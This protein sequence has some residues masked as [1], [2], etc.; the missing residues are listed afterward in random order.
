M[1]VS[2]SKVHWE[3]IYENKDPTEVSWYQAAPELSLKLIDETGLG[4]DAPIID[5]GGGTGPS[6]RS[7][8]PQ[9]TPARSSS[10][11]T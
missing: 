9:V 10:T 5:V 8:S 3:R 1:G 7:T 6:P 2:V 4:R 11:P